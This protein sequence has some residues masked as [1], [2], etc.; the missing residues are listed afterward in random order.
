MVFT[1]YLHGISQERFYLL[2]S[3]KLVTLLNPYGSNF[4]AISSELTG[5]K[6]SLGKTLSGDLNKR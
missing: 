6:I 4:R 1:L 2:I 3:S 5:L